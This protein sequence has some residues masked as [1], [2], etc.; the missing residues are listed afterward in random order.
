[1]KNR[2]K[3]FVGVSGG[4]DSSVSA[5]LL[6][7]EGHDVTGVFIRTWTPEWIPCTWRQERRDAMRVCAHLGIP[8]LE[9]DAVDSYKQGVVDYMIDEYRK[10]RT[11]NPDVMC[12][13]VVKFGIF[14]NFAVSHG[15]DAIATGHYAQNISSIQ[16]DGDTEIYHHSLVR[17]VDTEKDQSY[18]LWTLTQNDLE[19][20]LFPIGHLFKKKVRL[21]AKKYCL[22]TATKKDSQGVCFLGLID[23]KEFLQHYIDTQPGNI[24][25]ID[26]KKIGIHPGAVYFTIGERHGFNTKKQTVND[27]PLYVVAKD[28]KANTITVAEKTKNDNTT[29]YTDYTMVSITPV[30]WVLEPAQKNSICTA[31]ILYHGQQYAVTVSEATAHE[32]KIILHARPS[33]APGQSV[34]FYDGMRVIGGG[35]VEK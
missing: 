1:M 30:S 33:I 9:C 8:F 2:L 29:E 21:L 13:R 5:A 11:P 15:A 34:V 7:D 6:R 23:M 3:I 10:G 25:N 4:V 26:G 17:G 16:K 27:K 19:H 12:N 14:W 20:T 35:V 18:F 24:L 31:Q 28:M 22:P 32:A